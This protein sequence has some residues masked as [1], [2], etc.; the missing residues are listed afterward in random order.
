MSAM[1]VPELGFGTAPLLGRVSRRAGTAALA[2]AWGAGIRHFDT[3]RSYGWG[4]AE[5]VLGAFLSGRPR[6]DFRIVSKCGIVPARRSRLLQLAKSAG[7]AAIRLAPGLRRTANSIASTPAFAP[8]YS[9]DIGVLKA[10]LA[11]SLAELRTPYIDV[12]LLH[13]YAPGLSGLEQVGAWFRGVQAE[14]RIRRFGYSVEGDLI[15]GLE[16]LASRGLLEG[17]VIQSPVSAALLDLPARWRDVPVIA[18]SPLGFLRSEGQGMD[19]LGGLLTRLG[20]A[21]RCEALV[22]S[23]YDPGH[24]AANVAVWRKSAAS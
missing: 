18:H 23:M 20:S 5:Q 4:D 13:N 21:C 8:Q 9:A 15:E 11:T 6:G 1:S 24:L 7:R 2:R 14:G 10:S 22:C 17:A 19:G 3:A 16:D 12:L